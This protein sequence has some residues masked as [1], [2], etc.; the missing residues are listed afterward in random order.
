MATLYHQVWINASVAKLYEAISTADRIGSWWDKVKRLALQ[1]GL[2]QGQIR[3]L[4]LRYGHD[5][6]LFA[7]EAIKLREQ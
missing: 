3:G 7:A 2:T 4:L 5:W 6:D 1:H